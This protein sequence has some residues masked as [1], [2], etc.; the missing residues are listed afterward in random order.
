MLRW[1][2]L[3]FNIMAIYEFYE[4]FRWSVRLFSLLTILIINKV[5]INSV[6]STFIFAAVKANDTNNSK[7]LWY[8]LLITSN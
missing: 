7:L 8:H 3:M 6:T 2:L 1:F 4:F 5:S